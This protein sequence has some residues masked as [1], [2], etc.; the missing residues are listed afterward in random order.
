MPL[1]PYF[2]VARNEVLL[3]LWISIGVMVVA[4]FAFGWTKT[5]VVCGWSGRKNIRGCILGGIEMVIVGS[6]AAAAAV[7]LVRAIDQGQDV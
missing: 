2:C 3:A 5:G 7:G 4:L 1:V 6:V